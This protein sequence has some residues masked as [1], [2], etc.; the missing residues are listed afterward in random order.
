MS[1]VSGVLAIRSTFSTMETASRLLF[2]SSF[3]IMCHLFFGNINYIEGI[4]LH[5]GGK[6]WRSH[7]FPPVLK[8]DICAALNVPVFFVC[9]FSS[10]F[11]MSSLMKSPSVFESVV[12]G[13]VPYFFC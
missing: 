3:D 4:F 1:S 9:C 7:D 6:S 10:W 12:A 11:K 13:I 2:L 8:A 5:V